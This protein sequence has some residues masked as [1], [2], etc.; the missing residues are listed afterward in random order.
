V[1]GVTEIEIEIEIDENMKTLIL[2]NVTHSFTCREGA[3]PA[4]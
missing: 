4:S 3:L 1:I 2:T